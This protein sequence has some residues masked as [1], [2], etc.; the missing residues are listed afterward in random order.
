MSDARAKFERPDAKKD[1]PAIPSRPTPNDTK[2]KP[3]LVA[4]SPA[5]IKSASSQKTK[6][7]PP[8]PKR[9]YSSESVE[10]IVEALVAE[11]PPTSQKSPSSWIKPKTGEEK[12]MK[13]AAS[14]IK[15]KAEAETKKKPDAPLVYS[16]P[17]RIQRRSSF[18]KE[19]KPQKSNFMDGLLAGMPA[20]TR[21]AIGGALFK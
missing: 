15:P 9:T 10:N 14:W 11:D 5:V 12:K 6:S 16:S 20:E 3:A 8:I 18:D 2:T 17:E 19:G 13:P 4:K 21:N 7:S 1:K